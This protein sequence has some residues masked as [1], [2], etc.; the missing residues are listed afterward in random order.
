MLENTL[1]SPML[2]HLSMAL[3]NSS[4]KIYHSYA[5]ALSPTMLNEDPRRSLHSKEM[6]MRG[7]WRLAETR[8][9]NADNASGTGFTIL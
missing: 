3:G 6:S 7:Q 5:Q 2:Y 9:D 4:H 1:A 8:K